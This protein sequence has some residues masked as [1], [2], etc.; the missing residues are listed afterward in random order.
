M[1]IFL[2]S[3]DLG[4]CLRFI[5]NNV[6]YLLILKVFY[7]KPEDTEMLTIQGLKHWCSLGL[8]PKNSLHPENS[9]GIMDP[10]VFMRSTEVSRTMYDAEKYTNAGGIKSQPAGQ[11]QAVI[12]VVGLP[13][14][15]WGTPQASVLCS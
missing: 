13:T 4:K 11:I 9:C 3:R 15:M 6:F 7:S 8:H 1:L 14:R 12:H 5:I 10:Y 2:T